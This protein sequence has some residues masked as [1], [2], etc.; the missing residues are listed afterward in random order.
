V[1]GIETVFVSREL[2]TMSY[3]STNNDTRSFVK[4]LVSPHHLVRGVKNRLVQ[5]AKETSSRGDIERYIRSGGALRLNIGSQAN[6][7]D[8]WLNVDI[9][10][11]AD[12]VYLDATDM[13]SVP[14]GTFDAVLCEHMIEHVS[15]LDGIAVI[16]SIYR[17]LKQGGVARFVTPRLERLA[18]TVLKQSDN[19]DREIELFAH[20]FRNRKIGSEYPNFTR[21][22]YINVMFRQWGHQ[23]LYTRDDL[24]EKLRSVGFSSVIETRPNDIDSKFFEGAQGHGRL[25]GYEINDLC[26]FALEAAK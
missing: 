6:R 12:G 10:P 21:V 7:P 26:A 25:L 15:G 22:D 23:Y 8:G 5:R 1:L 17:I 16:R 20:E 24:A 13:K 19:F 18:Q 9:N 2:L 14:G 11:G 4:K 3:A